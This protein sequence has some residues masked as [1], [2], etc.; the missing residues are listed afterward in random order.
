MKKLVIDKKQTVIVRNVLTEININ[1]LAIA[2]QKAISDDMQNPGFAQMTKLSASLQNVRCE[3]DGNNSVYLSD[4]YFEINE[5]QNKLTEISYHIVIVDYLYHSFNTDKYKEFYN[6]KIVEDNSYETR[7]LN[8]EDIDLVLSNILNAIS[9]YWF[10][11][12]FKK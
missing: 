8:P 12:A 2:L 4:I 3:L 7:L 10:K 5:N 11:L 1:E 9:F 6:E